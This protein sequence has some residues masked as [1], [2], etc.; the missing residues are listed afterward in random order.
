MAQ[1]KY[2]FDI[3]VTGDSYAGELALPYVTP[4]IN[5]AN[6]IADGLVRRMDGITHKAVIKQLKDYNHG[7]EQP[8][9]V[10]PPRLDTW[11]ENNDDAP[12]P[13]TCF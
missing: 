11:R 9:S 13:Q 8:S 3:T 12:M 5:T 4:A 2:N 1:K 7:Q 6:S 10:D